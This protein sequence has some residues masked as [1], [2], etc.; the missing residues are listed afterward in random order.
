MYTLTIEN[1][2]GNKL[3]LTNNEENYQVLSVGG[4]NQPQANINSHENAYS[5]GSTFNSAHIGERNVV[6]TVKLN[7]DIEK[8]RLKLYEFASTSQYCKIYFESEYRNIYCEGYVENADNDP[9]SNNNIVQISIICNDPYLYAAGLIVVDI[10]NRRD[11]FTFPFSISKRGVEI[12][13]L[14][15]NRKTTIVNEGEVDTGCV[16]TLT[17]NSLITNPVIYNSDTGEFLKIMNTVDKDEFIIIDTH[18]GKK[19]IKKRVNGEELNIIGS[20]AYG[21]TWHI[22]K[23]GENNFIYSADDNNNGL[24]VEFSYNKLYKGI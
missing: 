22:L 11:N 17:A 21:S 5:D 15:E 24:F 4:L 7:G 16:I 8:N 3:T 6:I 13:S 20:L 19:S 14:V 1:R 10:S 23:R 18:F 9:F 2:A 12:S